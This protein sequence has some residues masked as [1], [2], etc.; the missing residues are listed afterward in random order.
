M[1]FRS[2]KN[3][4]KAAALLGTMGLIG[5]SVYLYQDKNA[6]KKTG[7]KVLNAMDNAEA[8]IAKKIN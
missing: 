4:V 1:L 2:M 5:A 3:M 8:M 7:K 6:R